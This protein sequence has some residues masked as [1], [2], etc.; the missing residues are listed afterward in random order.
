MTID[1]SEI[2]E[3][4]EGSGKMYRKGELARLNAETE[5]KIDQI[6]AAYG[7]AGKPWAE[8]NKCLMR[9]DEKR[10]RAIAREEIAAHAAQIYPPSDDA[11][12]VADMHAALTNC[13]H[14]LTR[15]ETHLFEYSGVIAKRLAKVA[16]AYAAAIRAGKDWGK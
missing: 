12:P 8:A 1:A 14:T 9:L 10:F 4:P 6:A 13:N 11:G 3:F 7:E 5:A 15:D 2:I 16:V